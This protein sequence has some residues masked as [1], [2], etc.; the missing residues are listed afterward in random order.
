MIHYYEDEELKDDSVEDEELE[1]VGS[2]EEEAEEE[3]EEKVYRSQAEV[4]AAIERKLARERR[5][6]AR[7]FGVKKLEEALPYY[8]A[9]HVVSKASGLKPGEVVTRL[10]G[11]QNP[12]V[13]PQQYN[14]TVTQPGVTVTPQI[15]QELDEIKSLLAEERTEKARKIQEAEA[16]KE[17]GNE[18]Y[19]EY[20]D[21]IED[22][23]DELGISLVDAAAMVL[24]GKLKDHVAKQHLEQQ[25]T[26]RR[27]KIEGTEDP[28]ADKG[29]KDYDAALSAEQK[30]VARKMGISLENYYKRLKSLGRVK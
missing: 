11:M 5:K 12:N 22:K 9:G 18:L 19:E 13:Y 8:Q 25:R 26:Q 2:S 10:Q 28:A 14:P 21:D 20:A 7:M 27:R 17:F 3:T 1:D 30:R 16:R 23:A 24:R 15:R 29:K 6:I 4:D